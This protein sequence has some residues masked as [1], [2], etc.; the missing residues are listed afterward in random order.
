[1]YFFYLYLYLYCFDKKTDLEMGPIMIIITIPAD[2]QKDESNAPVGLSVNS[3]ISIL[4]TVGETCQR[5][6]EF[7]FGIKSTNCAHILDKSKFNNKSFK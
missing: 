3:I 1:M 7:M 2:G 5:L 4:G 6:L